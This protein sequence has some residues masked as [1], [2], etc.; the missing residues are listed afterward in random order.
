[1]VSYIQK[2]VPFFYEQDLCLLKLFKRWDK[3]N[4][5]L[6]LCNHMFVPDDKVTINLANYQLR[7]TI[8]K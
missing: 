7:T 5:Q 6:K 3:V 1:M 8:D 4:Y 2:G